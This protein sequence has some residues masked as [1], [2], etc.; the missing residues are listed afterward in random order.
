MIRA[1]VRKVY[2]RVRQ[3]R[4]ANQVSEKRVLV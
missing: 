1:A 4:A 2:E 3:L